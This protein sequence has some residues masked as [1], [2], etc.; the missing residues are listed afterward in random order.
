MTKRILSV[1]YDAPLLATR[2]FLLERAGYEVIS[3]VGF[4]ESMDLLSDNNF[5]L[6]LLGHS[7]PQRDKTALIAMAKKIRDCKV[8][9]IRR[10]GDRPHPDANLS[11]DADDGPGALLDAVNS[12]LAET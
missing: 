12:V 4:T 5:D 8:L 2:H 3:G 11:V 1:S 6:F 9:S 7:I 10:H